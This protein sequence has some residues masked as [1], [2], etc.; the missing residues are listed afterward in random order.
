MKVF[1]PM[2]LSLIARCFEYRARTW[3]GVSALCMVDLG[4]PQT[5]PA[6]AWAEKDLWQFWAGR[7]EAEAPLEEG[8]VRTRA[9]YL[10]SGFAWPH[11]TDGRACAV[12]AEVGNLKK[13][14][15]VQGERL[16]QGDSP[17]APLPFEQMP[18]R[19]SHAFGGPGAAANPLGKGA[20]P[21]DTP[22]GRVHRLPNI[23][24]PRWPVT[25]PV[26]Q[27][28]PAGFGPIDPMWPQRAVHHGTYDD[29]WVRN[30]FPAIASD[31]NWTFFNV[32]P[33]D[34]QQA[35]PFRGDEPY[36]FDNMHATQPRLAGRLPG[37][38]ARAFVTHRVDGQEKFKEVRLRLNTLWFFP[39]A[40]RAI[41]VFQGM[42]AIAEDDGADIVHLMGALE[43]LDA[44]R[45]AE[46]YLAVRDKRLDKASGALESLRE[47][48]L[49]PADLVVP[50][51][52]LKPQ[53]NRGLERG[54]R[55]AES[56]RA[57][58]RALV[59][60]HGLD[61]DDGHAPPAAGPA[62]PEVRTLDDL[63]QLQK[64][65]ETQRV[66]LRTR[67]DAIRDAAVQEV[68]AH[69]EREKMDFSLVEREIAGLENR[70][71]P[72]PFA[73]DLKHSF[74]ALIE[75]GKAGGGDVSELEQMLVDP[76]LD[77]QWRDSEDKQRVTY[78]LNA[79]RQIP[80]DAVEGE[81]ATL[82]RQRVVAH[83]AA[84]GSFRGWDLTGANLSG[85]DLRGADLQG[86]WM[87]RANLTGTD[88][89]EADL[90]DAVLAHATLLSTQCQG[91]R[92][93]RANLGGAR[94]EK[95]DFTGADL[96]ETIFVKARLDDV[97][98]RGAR[99][100]GIRLEDAQLGSVDCRDAIA[101]T[102]LVFHQRDL[103]GWNLQGARFKQCVF[104]ECDLSGADFSGA[105]FEKCGFVESVATQALFRG[106]SIAS[107]CFVQG[108]V[109]TGADFSGAQLPQINFRGA[110]LVGAIF[111]GASLQGADFSECDLSGADFRQA[112]AR[113]ARFVRAQ[114]A[115]A[116]L[117]ATNLMEAVFQHARLDQTDYT[118]ANLYQ[119]DFARVR[120]AGPVTFDTAITTRMR[121]V[122]RHRPPATP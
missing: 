33:E 76:Q 46:H 102:M 12:S 27:V 70:G 17:T 11:R 19:W 118:Q 101:D 1:K 77:R 68:K 69:F 35:E 26:Q 106:L 21:V 44:P 97:S 36:A 89:Q 115:G 92:L 15:L 60:S 105:V 29:A 10:V 23:E 117:G 31:T 20:A 16:W 39:D 18:L 108:C 81:A 94:I 109:L 61:P 65:M 8:L 72:K 75:R 99:L 34:Q 7:A 79:H 100:D 49:M 114:L 59:V 32:A 3:L 14:L 4:D 121:T 48:D 24:N 38:G 56:A 95:A 111:R 42:H 67:G 74:A 54:Q 112:D 62:P 57:E 64:K 116:Q 53:E 84:K 85:L 58:A 110:A 51:F 91:A 45:P 113:Q 122:P 30:D 87:E 41:L 5:Q 6:R 37:L 98:W 82:L 9:E 55:R 63:I 52:D 25:S 50:L 2:P 88:L 104:V 90:Q 83:Q 71:P 73:A 43:R 120:L 47:E 103:R 107:G 80:V 119:S 40:E 78:R 86:V 13:Q 28:S 22:T 93:A 96:S 66:E